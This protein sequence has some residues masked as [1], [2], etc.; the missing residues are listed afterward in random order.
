MWG[1]S[2]W[3]R[4]HCGVSYVSAV[5][6]GPFSKSEAVKKPRIKIVTMLSAKNFALGG[7]INDR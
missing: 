6:Q 2:C 4:G 7:S 3:L 5:R 1:G